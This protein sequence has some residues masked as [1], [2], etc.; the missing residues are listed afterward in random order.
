MAHRGDHRKGDRVGIEGSSGGAAADA[1][2][3]TGAGMAGDVV[4]PLGRAFQ[5]QLGD[6]TCEGRVELIVYMA[7]RKPLHMI[8]SHEIVSP[9]VSRYACCS[10]TNSPSGR[11]TVNR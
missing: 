4:G 7:G 3:A 1:A 11:F 2:A 5:E 6:R 10:M 8:R 9:S